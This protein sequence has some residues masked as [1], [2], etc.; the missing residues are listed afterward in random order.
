MR[1]HAV[2][3]HLTEAETTVTT[4]SLSGLAC[5]NLSWT[6]TSGVDLVLDHV[7]E[8]LVVGWS[9]EDHHFHFLAGE[10]IVH[11]LVPTKLVAEAM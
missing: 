2:S 9:K 6:A 10:A 3:L 8:A 7:L 11:H 1:D 4:T 5:Q